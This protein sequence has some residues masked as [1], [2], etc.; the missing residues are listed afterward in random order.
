MKVILRA[1]EDFFPRD[2]E[3]LDGKRPV[4]AIPVSLMVEDREEGEQS[5]WS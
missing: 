1:I 5:R 4:P 3:A 2:E